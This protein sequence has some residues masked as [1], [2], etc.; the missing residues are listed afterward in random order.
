[1]NLVSRFSSCYSQLKPDSFRH[2]DD[3]IKILKSP[4]FQY[5]LDKCS[6]AGVYACENGGECTISSD[7]GKV[8]CQ[9]LEQFYGDQCEHGKH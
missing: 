8:E 4:I 6:P 1:M 2:I 7:G 5:H 9:C 3:N